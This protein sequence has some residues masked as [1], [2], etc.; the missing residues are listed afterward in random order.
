[1]ILHELYI[2]STIDSVWI[3]SFLTMASNIVVICCVLGFGAHDISSYR[4]SGAENHWPGFI[5]RKYGVYGS[6]GYWLICIYVE[7]IQVFHNK[8]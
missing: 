7:I 5:T 4:A 1:M 8:E 2:P 6:F 3:V